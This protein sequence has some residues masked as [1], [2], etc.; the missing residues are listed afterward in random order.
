MGRWA[1]VVVGLPG[2][3]KSTLTA[4]LARRLRTESVNSGDLLHAYLR[5][6]RVSLDDEVATGSVFLDNFG[7]DIVGDVIAEGS[8]ARNA[9]VIDGVR[10][11]SS[12]GGFR[13]L[14]V[15]PHVAFLTAGAELRHERFIERSLLDGK[16]RVA[17][18]LLLVQKDRWGSDL[19]RF[20]TISR[21]R[22]DN[23]G[24]LAELE[25]FADAIGAELDSSS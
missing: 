13:R 1:I 15:A 23:S 11:Y 20:E 16:D 2:V 14:G 8:V 18:E 12:L 7:E 6:Q 22:F 25:D 3:G 24:S 4:Y 17:A 21:W 10:L 5:A 19:P 9:Q